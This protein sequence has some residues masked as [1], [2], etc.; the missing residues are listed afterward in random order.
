M[1][2]AMVPTARVR[3]WEENDI[4]RREDVDRYNALYEKVLQLEADSGVSWTWFINVTGQALPSG[5]VFGFNAGTVNIAKADAWSTRGWGIVRETA[6][7]NQQ[8]KG[9]LISP[10]IEVRTIGSG[11]IVKDDP[12]YLSPSTAGCVTKTR[13]TTSGQFAQIIGYAQVDEKNSRVKISLANPVENVRELLAAPSAGSPV[14]VANRSREDAIAKET[15]VGIDDSGNITTPGSIGILLPYV[16]GDILYADTT[17]T[18]AKLNDVATGNAL[19]SGGIGVAPLWGKIGLTTH[20]SGVLAG[21]NGGTGLST[22]AVGDII[23]ASAT[24]PTWSRLADVAAGSYL[25]SGG[26]NTA[27]LWSTLILPNAATS[28]YL[29]YATSANTYGES[30]NLTFDGTNLIVTGRI[31]VSMTPGARL[32]VKSGGTTQTDGFRLQFSGSTNPGVILYE[33]GSNSGGL[34]LFSVTTENVR[35][36][37]NGASWVQGGLFTVGNTTGGGVATAAGDLYVLDDL[38]VDDFAA[39]GALGVGTDTDPGANVAQIVGSTQTQAGTS[40]VYARV[41][42]VLHVNTTTVGNVG[43]GVDD[44]MTYSVTG[45]TL[46]VNGDHLEFEA[47]GTCNPT[48]LSA[49][50]ITANFGSTALITFNVPADA[51][52]WRIKGTIIRTGSATQRAITTMWNDTTAATT[53]TTDTE[54]TTPAETLSGA[55]TLKCTG[56]P[57]SDTDNDVTQTLFIVKWYPNGN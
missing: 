33:I 34:R 26:V 20:I 7:N 49:V 4:Q 40:A 45:N 18:L 13:T 38:E 1:T 51:T 52:K 53:I 24:T 28:T 27:P 36:N 11:D 12:V 9:V 32:E 37:A 57:A 44:L 15:R 23:Y 16:V 54:Y 19:I 22:A 21:V 50:S 39:I 42:G 5:T 29:A 2:L 8:F 55:V 25:R 17:S 6:G 47:A 10:S 31:G 56:D 43:A 35:L 30:A 14:L 41:G 48:A 3:S 46:A